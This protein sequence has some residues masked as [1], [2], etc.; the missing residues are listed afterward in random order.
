MEMSVTREIAR[1]ADEVFDY[2]ADVSNNP[3]WQKGMQS[4]E[5]TSEPPIGGGSTYSQLARFMGKNIKSSFVV[6][7]FEP[8]RRIAIKTVESTFP[9]Q[10]ERRVEPTGPDSCRV[11]AQIGGGPDKGVAKLLAPIMARVAQKSVDGDYDRLV[12]LLESSSTST[13]TENSPSE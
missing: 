12:E 7:E 4:C 11:S 9:I 2:L 10:V 1:P 6:T 3:S 8:G 13:P 5:W